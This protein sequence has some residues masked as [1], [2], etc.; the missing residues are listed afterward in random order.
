VDFSAARDLFVNIFQM[1]GPNCKIPDCGLISEKQRGLSAKSAKIGPRVDFKETQGLL[2][3]ISE[4]IDLT[5]YFPTVK[6]VDRVHASVDR[7]GA[8]GSPWTDGGEDRGCRSA[9]VRSPEYGLRPLRCTKA[10]QQGRK[11]ERGA[12][13]ARFGPHRSSSGGVEAGRWRCRTGGGG[14]R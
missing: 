1:S 4:N 10:H 11:R 8:L 7:P 2:F 3:K 6:V 5:N 13:G 12:R 9:A 14:A